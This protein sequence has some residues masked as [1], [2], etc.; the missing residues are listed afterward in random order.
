M[1]HKAYI[2]LGTNLGDREE[3]LDCAINLIE[4]RGIVVD[5]RS[6]IYE[7]QPQGMKDQPWF[8]NM[9]VRVKTDLSARELLQALL[10]IEGRMGRKRLVRWGPRV[11]D[12]DILLFDREEIH[13]EDLCVPHPRMTERAFVLVPLLELAPDISLPDGTAL[14]DCLSRSQAASQ[15]VKLFESSRP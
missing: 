11:I 3:A 12:L 2:G 6:S 14:E 9:V 15:P 4:D 10:D 5:A 7:T 8:L 1:M 13:E